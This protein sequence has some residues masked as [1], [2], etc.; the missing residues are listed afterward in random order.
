MTHPATGPRATVRLQFHAGFTLDDAAAQVDYFADLGISHIYASPLLTARPGSTHGYDTL[1][2]GRVNPELGGYDALVRLVARLRGRSMGLIL[3]IVPNHMAVGGSGNP[4]WEDV[5]A[6]GRASRHAHMFDIDWAP[7][8]DT[9][10]DRV[11]APFLAGPYGDCLAKGE[12][13]LR[14]DSRDGRFACWHYEHCFPICPQHYADLL[15]ADDVSPPIA[16]LLGTL[17]A[18]TPDAAA[19]CLPVL[20]DWARTPEGRAAIDRAT[21][22]FTPATVAGRARL[23]ALLERQHY[24]LAWWR[25]AGDIINWRRFFD[26]TGLA[27][28]RVECPDVFDAVHGTIIALYAQGLID[29]V[30]VDHIDGLACPGAYCA[31]L[32]HALAAVASRRSPDIPPGPDGGPALY[33][34]K[35]LAEGERLPVCWGVDGTT[36]Y[37]FLEQV[38]VL[39]HDPR[40]EGAVDDLWVWGAG[41]ATSFDA[42]QRAAREMILDHTLGAELARLVHVLVGLARRD[43]RTRDF[44][45]AALARVLRRILVEFPVY[46]TYA[47]D[48]HA[49]DGPPSA[50]G[51]G[52]RVLHDACRAARVGLAPA[53][54][55]VLA[56]LERQL[57][58]GGGPPVAAEAAEAV[59][60]A[61]IC[62]EHLTA[63]LAAKAVED[64]S[65]Y[66][67]GRL[68]SRNDVGTHP[69]RFAGTVAAFHVAN[70]ARQRDWPRAM[71]ATAT[72]DHKRG[73]DARARLAVLSER[74]HD[75]ARIAMDWSAQN[76]ARRP[77]LQGRPQDGTAPGRPPDRA[78]DRAD[79]LI[80]Y[81]ALI[82]AW[83]MTDAPPHTKATPDFRD[84]MAAWQVKALREAKRHTSWTDPD[85]AYEDACR[86][87][88]DALLSAEASNAFL[89]LLDGFVGQIAPAGAL[90]GLAQTLLRLT[91]PG[92]PDLYQGCEFWDL[93]LVDPDNRRPVDFAARSAAWAAGGD[94]AS[95]A[96]HWRDGRV[97]QALIGAV[98]QFRAANPALFIDGAYHPIRVTGPRRRHLVAFTRTLD[99][100]AVLVL[101][102]RLTAGLSPD[103]ADLSCPPGT[104]RSTA[105]DWGDGPPGAHHAGTWR[106]LLRPG[107]VF[108]AAAT[109]GLAMLAGGMPLDVLVRD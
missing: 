3:D 2:Y 107:R 103:P 101:A 32:R 34:E 33:V 74:G 38:D 14:H 109:R 6:W 92:V 31:R 68:L 11:L 63:P 45:P 69:G 15:G 79:E 62:F 30:R 40:G 102:P 21:A 98:L 60:D 9:V 20:A 41:G 61:I 83:P 81:Q 104:W 87:F 58:G 8:D 28:L 105:L 7:P 24:R 55:P 71:L 1:D 23:H 52:D 50:R 17:R 13:V 106:S 22:R 43:P 47:G 54:F 46:R 82:G 77:R 88:L 73:E 89:P 67:Y 39:L 16:D 51:A 25:T 44:T 75:W 42:E 108:D 100:M 27:G 35:I 29:G 78:P 5:L 94:C 19:A 56:W 90:N 12:L 36:G 76:A 72:H 49:S 10:R 99:G 85:P 65:F 96:P 48:G 86:A 80:L 59:R 95:L 26:I 97:K 64:T 53:Q 4:W 70:V 91:S 57:G 18:A 84:R 37:D 66:R 93:S